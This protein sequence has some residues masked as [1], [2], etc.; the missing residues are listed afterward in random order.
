MAAPGV[1]PTLKFG[2]GKLAV[3]VATTLG[4]MYAVIIAEAIGERA[5]GT[6]IAEAEI[7]EGVIA[8]MFPT[9]G[10][11]ERVYAALSTLEPR[12]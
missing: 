2:D 7:G 5:P 4:G 10:Q 11:A 3:G 1:I 9:R 12:G 8:L 6:P